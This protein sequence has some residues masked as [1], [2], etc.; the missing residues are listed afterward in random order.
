[1]G[2]YFVVLS[3]ICAVLD[4]PPANFRRMRINNGSVS[5]ID[6]EKGKGILYSLNDTCFQELDRINPT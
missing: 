5:I 3:I 4:L 6:F 2:H 1:V